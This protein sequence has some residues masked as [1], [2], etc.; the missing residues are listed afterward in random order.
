MANP[1]QKFLSFGKLALWRKKNDRVLGIDVGASSVKI[2]QLRR[3]KGRVILE[4]YGEIATGPYRDLS[5]GQVAVLTTEKRAEA[6]KY[7]FKESNVTTNQASFGIPL[8]SSLL[9]TIEIPKVEADMLAKVIPIEARKY[10]PV[11]ISEVSLDWWVIP[12]KDLDPSADAGKLEVLIVAIHNSTINQYQSLAKTMSLQTA[13]LE[14]ETFSA[15]R[16]SLSGEMATTAILDLGAG[17]TKMVI[18][19]HGIVKLSHTIGKGSQDISMAISRS[20]GLDF[21]KAEEVKRQVG[22]VERL[23]DGRNISTSVNSTLEYIFT[24]VNKVITDFQTRE[25]KVVNK[26]VL[27]GGGSLLKGLVDV[28]GRSFS[29]PV[30]LGQPFAKVEAPAFLEP[31]LDEV[32]P[33]FAVALGLA[34]RHLQSLD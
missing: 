24:D 4:T 17:T 19:D 5:V 9:V 1:F 10:I 3:S 11:P 16:S 13:F 28:A 12:R 21:G 2:V 8:G 15:M 31:I 14:I 27:L 7:L 29:A 33:T 20:L 34:L 26:I 30:V 23:E 32:G 6:I 22:L 18:V 25:R